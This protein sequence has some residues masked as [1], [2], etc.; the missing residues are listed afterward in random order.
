MT[1][2]MN[3]QNEFEKALEDMKYC[4]SPDAAYFDVGMQH[5]KAILKSLEF[6]A[7]NHEAMRDGALKEAGFSI[8]KYTNGEMNIEN[9]G[10]GWAVRKLSTYRLNVHTLEFDYEPMP[11]SRTEEWIDD[12]IFAD[13]PTALK[14]IAAAKLSQGD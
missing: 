12:H 1:E 13:I 5:H 4:Y 2:A 11:S 3:E 6:M 14:A 10:M 9:T 7:A 8:T